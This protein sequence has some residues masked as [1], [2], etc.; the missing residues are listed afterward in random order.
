MSDYLSDDVVLEQ[1]GQ[2][3]KR[4]DLARIF[5]SKLWLIVPVFQKEPWKDLRLVILFN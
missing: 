2:R 5:L 4:F 1:M 3:I